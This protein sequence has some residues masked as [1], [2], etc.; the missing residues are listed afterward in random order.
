MDK[1]DVIKFM[2]GAAMTIGLF[3]LGLM[4]SKMDK[5]VDQIGRNTA[6]ITKFTTLMEERNS[7]VERFWEKDWVELKDQV[8][9]LEIRLQAHL[10]DEAHSE[11]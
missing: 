8:R 10:L 11:K 5:M 7:R 2:L 4:V 9:D 3:L 1:D 6:Q